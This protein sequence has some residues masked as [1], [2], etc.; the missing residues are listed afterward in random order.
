VQTRLSRC[1]NML[2][3]IGVVGG[4]SYSNITI[5]SRAQMLQMTKY[6]LFILE[7]NVYL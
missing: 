4:R 1:I 2:F 7:Y 6:I 5:I 3:A